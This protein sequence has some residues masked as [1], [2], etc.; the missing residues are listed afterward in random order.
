MGSPRATGC[1]VRRHVGV[2]C[3]TGWSGLRGSPDCSACAVLLPPPGPQMGLRGT[4]AL[5]LRKRLAR[6]EG[7]GQGPGG[8][9][10]N[11][12][13]LWV[14]LVP[15]ENAE[16]P[17]EGCGQTQAALR[18]LRRHFQPKDSGLGPGDKGAPSGRHRGGRLQT[19]AAGPEVLRTPLPSTTA[20]WA[21]PAPHLPAARPAHLPGKHCLA[22][23]M[24]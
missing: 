11:W 18:C 23:T 2:H 15:R 17:A 13:S 5:R 24:L 3:V 14:D 1:G 16:E 19:T 22:V 20:P 9:G 4:R 7:E 8:E 10:S 21:S 6:G 12:A